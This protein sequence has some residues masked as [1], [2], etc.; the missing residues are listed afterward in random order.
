MVFQSTRPVRG[1]TKAK[2]NDAEAYAISIHPPRAGRDSAPNASTAYVSISIHPPHAGRDDDGLYLIHVTIISIHP[3]HAGRD[4]FSIRPFARKKNFNPPA[5]C[6]AGRKAQVLQLYALFISI[7]PPHAGRDDQRFHFLVALFIS[8]H[9]PH[10]GRDAAQACDTRNTVQ[11]QSTR[12]MRGG[13][14]NCWN[15]CIICIFQS[16][17]PM[18][19]GTLEQYLPMLANIFQSTRP[20]RGGTQRRLQ[21]T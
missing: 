15:C 10:A 11:F 12:P 6:G 14:L 19:G 16:T 7:H 5:P 3:P 2:V 4:R 20:M 9:P 21:K 18:R 1:G 8:I 17:R 13:T